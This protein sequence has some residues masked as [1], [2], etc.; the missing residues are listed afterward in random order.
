MSKRHSNYIQDN[1]FT[2]LT[3]LVHTL[4]ISSTVTC[5][6]DVVHCP[7]K[8]SRFYHLPWASTRSCAT[9]CSYGINKVFASS[10]F[11]VHC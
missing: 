10:G 4:A 1:C 2:V 9:E 3:F 8:G 5:Y 6:L 7:L 11:S